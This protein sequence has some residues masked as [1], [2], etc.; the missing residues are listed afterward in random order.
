MFKQHPVGTKGPRVSRENIPYCT[1]TPPPAWTVGTR[2]DGSM[3]SRRLC[4]ILTW[5]SECHSICNI[6]LNRTWYTVMKPPQHEGH[7]TPTEQPSKKVGDNV[8]R[9]S[10]PLSFFFLN[11]QHQFYHQQSVNLSDTNVRFWFFFATKQ[12]QHQN[13]SATNRKNKIQVLTVGGTFWTRPMVGIAHFYF[14]FVCLLGVYMCVQNS[15]KVYI[16][17]RKYICQI[18]LENNEQHKY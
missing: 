16:L 2:Q 11:H 6:I 12:K 14:N 13:V 10:S 5:P 4:L 15:K 7:S 3:I 17:L 9:I 18:V 8:S 1:I